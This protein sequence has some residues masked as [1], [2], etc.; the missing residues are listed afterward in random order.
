VFIQSP[1]RMPKHV[2]LRGERGP[3]GFC[4][5][6]WRGNGFAT[7]STPILGERMRGTGDEG[8]DVRLE[9]DDSMDMIDRRVDPLLR[10]GVRT[11]HDQIVSRC[12]VEDESEETDNQLQGRGPLTRCDLLWISI[13]RGWESS[14]SSEYDDDG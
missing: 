3:A 13:E 4:L 2:L 12:S 5:R 9:S 1:G 8:G 14:I 11:V 6:T 10:F 7:H